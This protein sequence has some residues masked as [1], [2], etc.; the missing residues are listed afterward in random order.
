MATKTLVSVDEYLDMAF[1]GTD[2][3]YVDGEI[4]ERGMPEDPHSEVQVRLVQLFTPFCERASLHLRTELR[5]RV[6]ETRVRVGDFVVIRGDKPSALVPTSPP[7]VVAEIVSRHD[8]H[9][10][11]TRKLEEYREWGVAHVWL[12]DP[13]VR[14]LYVFKDGDFSTVQAFRLPELGIE[15]S[16]EEIFQ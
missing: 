16:S 12:I 11:I 9:T 15:L 3:E 14:R 4:V 2:A 7:L 6:S 5:L 8:R 13:W 10:E 1:E